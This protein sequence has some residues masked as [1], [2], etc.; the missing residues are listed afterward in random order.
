LVFMF[1]WD[2]FLSIKVDRNRFTIFTKSQK[3][4]WGAGM[5]ISGFVRN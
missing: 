5:G 2:D 4:G 1:Q 3:N